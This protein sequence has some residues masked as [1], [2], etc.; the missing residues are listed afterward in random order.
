MQSDKIKIVLG[1]LICF[2][3]TETVSG[4]PERQIQRSILRQQVVVNIPAY[5]LTLYTQDENYS[6]KTLTIPIGV[7][8]G[9]KASD[10]TPTGEGY[11]YAKATGVV[12]RYGDQ[13]PANLVGKIIKYSNTFDKRTLKPIRIPMPKDMRS[14]FMAILSDETQTVQERYVLHQTTDW[15]TIGV[16]ASNGCIRIDNEDMQT[17]Y[18]SIAPEVPSGRFP[19][20]IPISIH[21]EIIE[22]DKDQGNLILHANIY[23]KPLNYLDEILEI[24]HQ[25]AIDL[26]RIDVPQ[27]GWRIAEAE[28]QFQVAEKHIRKKLN[29][30]PSK[31][32]ILDGEK[33]QLHYSIFLSEILR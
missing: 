1:L 22:Y 17:F 24:F 33:Q 23:N 21:Y 2:L 8:S 5:Q 11:L 12:F 13:N 32:L 30:P 26:G 29:Q 20:P 27:L 14:V 31:R 18:T 28:A 16:P 4:R 10:E 6:W 9:I 15:H 19:L 3:S 25:E 7:G